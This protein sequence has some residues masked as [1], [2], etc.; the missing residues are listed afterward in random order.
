MSA[1][2][3]VRGLAFFLAWC[4]AAVNACAGNPI[5][6]ENAKPGTADWQL[7]S[8]SQYREIEGYASLTSVNRG[9][10]ISLFVNTIAPSYTIDIYRVGWY[11]G[12]GGRQ[13]LGPITRTGIRQDIPAPDSDGL[14]ECNWID[15]FVVTIPNN[16]ADPLSWRKP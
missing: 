10:T 8:P 11:G 1:R 12:L 3:V 7:V 16:A 14:I 9:G 13:V 4:L 15:P 6:L 5:Q 2:S